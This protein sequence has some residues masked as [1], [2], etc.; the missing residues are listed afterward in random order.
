VSETTVGPVPP[1][2]TGDSP[3]RPRLAVIRRNPVAVVIVATTVLALGLRVYQLARPGVLL[4]L[5]EYDDG[6]YFGSLPWSR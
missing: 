3:A 6:S 2:P 1:A 5:T 4:G